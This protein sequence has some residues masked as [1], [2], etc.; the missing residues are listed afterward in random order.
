MLQIIHVV[1]KQGH[2]RKAPLSERDHEWAIF[3]TNCHISS[4][5]TRVKKC[6]KY[7]FS[8]TSQ[9]QGKDMQVSPEV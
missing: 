1:D 3:P 2:F 5:T 8:L 7:Q 6:S 9:L 4:G